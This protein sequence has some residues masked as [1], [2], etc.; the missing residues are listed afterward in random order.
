M[1]EPGLEEPGLEQLGTQEAGTEGGGM[2]D[3]SLGR[4]VTV[5]TSPTKTFESLCR[6]PTW[7]AVLL[8]LMLVSIAT[9]W[10]VA[11]RLDIEEVIQARFAPQSREPSP[12]EME[13]ALAMA[14]KWTPVMALMGTGVGVPLAYLFVALCFWVVF[15]M[16]GS[17]LSFVQSF[18]VTLHSF[19]PWAIS[20]LLSI[21]VV[22]SRQRIGYEES[23]TGVL[24][25]NLGALAGE[26]TGPALRA[27]L[28]SLDVF[29]LWTLVLLTLGFAVCARRSK[30]GAAAV[31]LVLWLLSVAGKV[32]MAS[33]GS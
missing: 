11:Q 17:E 28:A 13:R 30:A 2:E 20:G 26:D 10:L 29:T 4:L 33:L 31:V 18:S 27:L 21:P 5:L 32:G 7:A 15:K 14:E 19:L 23:Q 3:S 6:R 16:L 24:L 1:E 12:A 9:G 8:A 25:S 22:L